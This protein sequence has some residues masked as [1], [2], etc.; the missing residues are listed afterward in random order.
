M[1]ILNR[2]VPAINPSRRKFLKGAVALAASTAL[3]YPHVVVGQS[4]GYVRMDAGVFGAVGDGIAD[5]TAA[6]NA[7]FAH[8]RP[9]GGQMD[10]VP[11]PYKVG[12]VDAT[13]LNSVTV[14]G[15]GGFVGA[16]DIGARFICSSPTHA[17]LDMIAS[18]MVIEHIGWHNPFEAAVKCAVMAGQEEGFPAPDTKN[19]G[20]L[21]SF[22]HVHTKGKFSLSAF[23]SF[24]VGD[25][26]MELCRWWNQQPSAPATAIIGRKNQFGVP[27]LYRL[28]K[29]AEGG[30]PPWTLRHSE[31]H[32]FVLGV[33]PAS[34][35]ALLLIG[36]SLVTARDHC[37]FDSSS[38]SQGSIIC[39]DSPDGIHCSNL[40]L[41]EAHGY[42]ENNMPPWY[43]LYIVPGSTLD[44]LSWDYW[45]QTYVT[46]RIFGT[47]TKII[48]LQAP[49]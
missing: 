2:A 22:R 10:V 26:T 9:T 17:A 14:R 19:A 47:V 15:L 13:R 41:E 20:T 8:L 18:A 12:S 29:M 31:F 35:C 28:P 44:L 5:D 7:A 21:L 4:Y 30:V 38:G 45:R 42:S 1:P 32:D 49:V 40:R 3:V 46:S 39:L 37:S 33:R 25:S 16:D 36:T 6:F 23:Y 11:R 24:G 43:G 48:G 34:G 27:S